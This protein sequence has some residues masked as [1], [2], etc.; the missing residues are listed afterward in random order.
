MKFLVALLILGSSLAA[1]ATGLKLEATSM[2]VGKDNG[3]FHVY[4]DGNK[5]T[6]A[7]SREDIAQIATI[8]SASDLR[9]TDGPLEVLLSNGGKITVSSGYNMDST[10][11]I[12]YVTKEGKSIELIPQ[13]N[14]QL[15]K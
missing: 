11:P 7:S 2:L 12:A 15:V 6:L 10:R 9:G 13:L 4:I 1:Q 14:V 5:V 3:S 8:V